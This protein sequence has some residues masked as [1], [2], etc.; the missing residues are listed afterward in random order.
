[1]SFYNTPERFVYSFNAVNF[2]SNT[3]R[4]FK[5]P[6]GKIGKV[7]EISAAATTSFTGTTAPG[8]IKLG[9]GVTATKYA[10]L[11]LGAAGAGPAAGTVVRATDVTKI[12]SGAALKGQ[13]PTSLP[14]TFIAA[15]QLVT[16]G[17]T[18]PTGTPAGVADVTIVVE[19][20]EG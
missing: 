13:D 11:V 15:D 14:F 7:V 10:D 9:D 12:G 17:F 5:G 4:Y 3:T 19:Y 6:N 2:G 8:E 1:M 18:A 16:I 20:F